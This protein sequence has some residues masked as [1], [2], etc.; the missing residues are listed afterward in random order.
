MIKYRRYK[1]WCYKSPNLIRDEGIKKVPKISGKVNSS[2]TCTGLFQH[3]LLAPIY[4]C[5][6]LNLAEDWTKGKIVKYIERKWV[7]FTK[8][9]LQINLE[10]Y[11]TL[12]IGKF[13]FCIVFSSTSTLQNYFMKYWTHITVK[14]ISLRIYKSNILTN[15]QE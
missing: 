14:A 4:T 8:R 12:V 9:F 11:Y 2:D 3:Y 13:S 6:Q 15:F 5:T 7:W 1:S 10:G